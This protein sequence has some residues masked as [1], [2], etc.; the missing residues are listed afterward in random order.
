MVI[1]SVNGYTLCWIIF[2][3]PQRVLSDPTRLVQDLD[4]PRGHL[5]VRDFC[6]PLIARVDNLLHRPRVD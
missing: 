3:D 2:S 5:V 4:A 6:R 1:H